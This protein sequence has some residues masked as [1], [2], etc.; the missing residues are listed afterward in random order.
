MGTPLVRG[1]DMRLATP[2]CLPGATHYRADVALHEDIAEALPYLNAELEGADYNHAARVLLWNGGGKRY[3]F[4]PR[5]IAIAPVRDREEA[6]PLA[7]AIIRTVNEIWARRDAIRPRF[8]GR[9]PPPT[10]LEIYRLLPR[11]NCRE[12]GFLS[13]MAFATAVRSDPSKSAL[14]PHAA[15]TIEGAT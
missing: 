10:A 12:C 3:A 13:C 15:I 6:D 8:E 5:G 14:C 7:R 4:R 11:T 2:D 9:R 1:F